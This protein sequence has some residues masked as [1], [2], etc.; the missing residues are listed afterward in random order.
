MQTIYHGSSILFS[1]F[2]LSHALE[3]DGK[4]KSGYG[5]YVISHYRSC[6]EYVGP[7]LLGVC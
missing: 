6:N 3:D 4:V 1:K 5:V 7:N 2:D